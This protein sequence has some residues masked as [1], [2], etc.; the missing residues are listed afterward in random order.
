MTRPVVCGSVHALEVGVGG[1]E[2]CVSR[3]KEIEDDEHDTR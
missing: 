1:R 2:T 3:T